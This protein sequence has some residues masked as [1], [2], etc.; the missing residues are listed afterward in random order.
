MQAATT[1]DLPK[2][3]MDCLFLSRYSLNTLCEVGSHGPKPGL[4][5]QRLN[6]ILLYIDLCLCS[7]PCQSQIEL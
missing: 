4:Q 7:K 6:F 1:H 2:T 3:A 5:V